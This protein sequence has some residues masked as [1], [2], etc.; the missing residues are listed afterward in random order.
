M[1]Q[2]WR[3]FCQVHGW[4]YEWTDT[5][6]TECPIDPNDVLDVDLTTIVSKEVPVFTFLPQKTIKSSNFERVLSFE[7]DE[8]YHGPINRVKVISRSDNG[9]NDYDIEVYNSDSYEVVSSDSF[10]SPSYDLKSNETSSISNPP[11]GKHKFEINAKRTSTNKNKNLHI[12][13]IIVFAKPT[14]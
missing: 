3:T 12:E 14:G 8:E 10:F 1:S 9:V 7:Y 4:Q 13:Q 6:P 11:Q 5:E 2:K